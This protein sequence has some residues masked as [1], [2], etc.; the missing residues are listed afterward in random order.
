MYK[1]ILLVH[2]GSVEFSPILREG[3][4]LANLSG[5][6]IALLSVVPR[7]TRGTEL[8]TGAGGGAIA[9]VDSC[10]DELKRAAAWLKDQGLGSTQRLAVGDRAQC[11][12]TAAK[13]IEADLVVV[14]GEPM[15]F[16]TRWWAR[17]IQDELSS[18]LNCSILVVR[19]AQAPLTQNKG[20]NEARPS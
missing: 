8:A 2:E 9:E 11:I 17:T 5:A 13:E 10:M 16:F 20:W 15:N 12:S 18:S 4:L 7:M 14:V 3:V 6:D 1:R 19:S